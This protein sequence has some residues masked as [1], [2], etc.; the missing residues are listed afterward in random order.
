MTFLI[1]LKRGYETA[2]T[3]MLYNKDPFEVQNAF[4]A[5]FCVGV[6]NYH[7]ELMEDEDEY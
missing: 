6:T 7:F 1:M 2:F 5:G 4:I 3:S